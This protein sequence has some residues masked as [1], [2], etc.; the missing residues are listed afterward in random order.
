MGERHREMAVELIYALDRHNPS[1]EDEYEVAL[2]I[3]QSAFS[4]VPMEARRFI[5]EKF[6]TRDLEEISFFKIT[7]GLP[8]GITGPTN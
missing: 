3:L 8:V 1:W 2:G 7:T 4:R 5:M 6:L